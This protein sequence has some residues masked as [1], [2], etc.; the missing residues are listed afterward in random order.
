MATG[1][2]RR[3]E[4]H[5][6]FPPYPSCDFPPIIFPPRIGAFFKMN[7]SVGRERSIGVSFK[8]QIHKQQHTNTN[9]ISREF[10]INTPSPWPM[11]AAC[12]RRPSTPGTTRYN[13][14]S[15]RLPRDLIAPALSFGCDEVSAATTLKCRANNRRGACTI[16]GHHQWPPPPPSSARSYS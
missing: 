5:I 3:F 14:L 4:S 7:S 11:V 13:P 15:A 10:I 8:R 1:G 6:H 16:G 12:R 2:R 9:T